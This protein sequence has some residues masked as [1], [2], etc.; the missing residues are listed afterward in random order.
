M[1]GDAAVTIVYP[2]SQRTSDHIS[3]WARPTT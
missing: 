2:D 1:H 3:S